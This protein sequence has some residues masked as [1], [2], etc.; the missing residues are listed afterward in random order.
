MKHLIYLLLLYLVLS[1]KVF[2]TAQFPD[3]LIYEGET[4]GIFTNPLEMYFDEKHPRPDELFKFSC[5]AN[6]RGYLATWEIKEGVL[7]LVKLV[8]GSCGENAPEI[9]LSKLF[10][11]QTAPIKATWFSGELKI[12]QGKQL[13]YVHMGYGSIYEKELHLTIKNGKLVNKITID[14][15]KKAMPNVEQQTI[16]ELQKL[17]NWE[18]KV[19]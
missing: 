3:L 5:T 7:Y 17:K 11:N 2:A 16:D 10:P 8:D 12:P 19:K 4:V 18:E 14:N 9:P 13:Q 15:S 6:W 1:N